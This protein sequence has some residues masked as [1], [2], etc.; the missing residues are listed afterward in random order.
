M[1]NLI[2]PCA[3][4]G[5]LN[6]VPKYLTRHPDGKLL[7]RKCIE[8]LPGGVFDRILVAIL[9][10]D[11][12]IYEADSVVKKAFLDMPE[13]EVIVLPEETAGPVETIYQTICIGNIVG[14]I[15]IKDSDNYLQVAEIKYR[16]FVAGLDLNEWQRDVHNLRNKSF[17]IL[18]E[19]KQILDVFEK[20]FKSDVISVGL[21]GFADVEDFVLAYE[22]LNDPSYPIKKLY[23]SH[24]ISYLI[25]YSQKVFHYIPCLDYENW[26]NE[27]VWNH[28]QKEY[29]T[30]FIDLDRLKIDE[31]ILKYME[32][33]QSR[34]ATFIGFTAGSDEKKAEIFQVVEASGV[35]FKEIVFGCS[36]SNVK[37]ILDSET[38][39][40]SIS[41][42]L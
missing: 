19:Q 38:Q 24:I 12:E 1:R 21:Y 37:V 31:K 18:N 30:Y 42:E 4:R 26:G 36:Y 33:L 20:K 29:A 5:L 15:V 41:Y 3:G 35:R 27:K 23:V 2:I 13:V 14:T 7:V 9:K 11:I 17:L 34:G 10:K 6:G 32:Q 8:G 39:L 40:T 22:K 25:G 16:N 28:V